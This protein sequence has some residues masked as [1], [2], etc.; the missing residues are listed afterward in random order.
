MTLS[1]HSY[2]AQSELKRR[3]TTCR[4]RLRRNRTTQKID[5]RATAITTA[6]P[7]SHEDSGTGDSLPG[8]ASEED[9]GGADFSEFRAKEEM[10]DE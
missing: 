4:E 5:G 1:L 2:P 7:A 9:D 6:T 8:D 10:T 3:I